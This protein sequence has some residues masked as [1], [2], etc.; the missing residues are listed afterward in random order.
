MTARETRRAK[1][2]C[3]CVD[4]CISSN[5]NG[6]I[7]PY[8]KSGILLKGRS[9]IYEC[10]PFCSCSLHCRNRVTQ[11]GLEHRLKVFRSNES[12]WGVRSLDLILADAFICEFTGLVLT[13]QQVE[14][15]TMDIVN[16]TH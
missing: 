1:E 5:K 6:N 9:L 3:E 8:S 2:C 14:I 12:S 13:R 15:L 7:F 11:K 4:G 16:I 10:S